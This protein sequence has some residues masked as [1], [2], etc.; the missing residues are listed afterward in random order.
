MSSNGFAY[1]IHFIA[2]GC[3]QLNTALCEFSECNIQY[4]YMQGWTAMIL[5]GII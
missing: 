4:Y 1:K 5:A 2:T 3:N